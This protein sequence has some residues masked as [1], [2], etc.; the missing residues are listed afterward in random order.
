M[1]FL[2]RCLRDVRTRSGDLDLLPASAQ[3]GSLRVDR[4][5]RNDDGSGVISSRFDFDEVRILP[6]GNA[7]P[8]TREVDRHCS[9]PLALASSMFVTGSP[10]EPAEECSY[11]GASIPVGLGTAK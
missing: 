4:L 11:S 10:R 2:L 3:G 5:L 8:M 1:A 9:P 7:E 6:G